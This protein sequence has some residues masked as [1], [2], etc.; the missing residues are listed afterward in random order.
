MRQEEEA[1]A[2]VAAMVEGG[3][4]ESLVQ[5]LAGFNEASDDEAEAVA[6]TLS[7]FEN[8]VELDPQVALPYCM[9]HPRNPKRRS[10]PKY[11]VHAWEQCGSA[12]GLIWA[13][14]WGAG[15]ALHAC[16]QGEPGMCCARCQGSTTMAR[17]GAY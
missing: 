13:L 6:N 10:L 17:R 11:D 14:P 4:L 2:L 16:M 5:R 3:A 7:L 8:M 12:G 9:L 15:A 1:R